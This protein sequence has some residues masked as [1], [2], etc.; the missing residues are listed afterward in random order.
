MSLIT[1]L[2]RADTR[3]WKTSPTFNRQSHVGVE[4]IPDTVHHL[5]LLSLLLTSLSASPKIL[6][7]MLRT[8][9]N[10]FLFLDSCKGGH[11]GG[12]NSVSCVCIS[13]ARPALRWGS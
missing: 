12:E 6:R 7:V 13:C 5:G 11:G 9:P 8:I 2:C 4:V 10:M 3:G 1:S